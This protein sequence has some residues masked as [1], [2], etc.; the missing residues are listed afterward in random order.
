MAYE[1]GQH[2]QMSGATETLGTLS[3]LSREE[4]ATL[5]IRHQGLSRVEILEREK[6]LVVGRTKPS[7]V[8]VSSGKL[9]RQHAR[10]FYSE[11]GVVVEDLGSHNG[12][13]LGGQKTKRSLLR[14]G[15]TLLLG[16][17]TVSIHLHEPPEATL[18]GI[19]THGRFVTLLEAEATR[20]RALGTRAALLFV[21]HP[22]HQAAA[23]FVGSVKG[24]LQP[25]DSVS[26]YTRTIIEVLLTDLKVEGSRAETTA[27]ALFDQGLVCGGALLPGSASDAQH[28]ISCARRALID[29]SAN[30]A[31]QLKT[32]PAPTSTETGVV[33]DSVSMK[34][35]MALVERVAS[36]T[37]PVLIYG[38]TGSGKE[39]VARAIHE[40]SSR[41]K[42]PLCTVNCGA[43]LPQLVESS[44]F[45]HERGAFTGADRQKKGLFE[46]ARGGTLF[47]DEIG[48]LPL[49]AQASLLRVLET[50]T[51]VR[52]GGT[53]EI[54]VDIRIVAATHRGLESMC[55]TGTFR[56][57]L[58]F[59]L[60]VMTLHLPPLRE[61]PEDIEGLVQLF[62]ERAAKDN[63]RDVLAVSRKARE[64]LYQY[65]WPGNVRELRNE[66][67]RAVVVCEGR[68]IMPDDLSDRV[69]DAF[70]PTNSSGVDDATRWE[71]TQGT[72]GPADKLGRS[73]LPV[74]GLS[75]RDALQAYERNLI[76]Q[77][78]KQCNGNQTAAAR[79][80]QLPR[81]T[82]VHK[83]RQHEIRGAAKGDGSLSEE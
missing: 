62:L 69:R 1:N 13:I 73:P 16:D 64:V 18:L 38:E 2:R 49:I 58:L 10:F 45:G 83:I 40:R 23:S 67:E 46:E 43:L 72:L 82:L 8:V 11:E 70:P 51:I 71:G 32:A 81:R 48:E 37:I 63:S 39:V 35:M 76:V 20:T 74:E 61:H 30:R 24:L 68:S 7:D 25:Q 53:K 52:V 4:H 6:E 9:S 77:A 59:R 26:T 57:D 41:S 44:L 21:Q 79:Y 75:L 50:K 65:A 22:V 12:T 28:L 3:A 60:N 14:S 66:I 78:L 33:A 15:D 27:R 31:P 19:M 5:L 80:L 17:V 29:A 34:K 42:A 56:Q 47:L 36:S 54:P 55:Q